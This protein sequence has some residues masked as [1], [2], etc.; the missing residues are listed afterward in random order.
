[1]GEVKNERYD[2]RC[3]F[4]ALGKVGRVVHLYTDGDVKVQA[5]GGSWIFNP[6]AVTKVSQMQTSDDGNDGSYDA[7]DPSETCI[8]SF[9]SSH[10]ERFSAMLKKVF[11]APITGDVHEELVKASAN[12]TSEAL[13]ETGCFHS[14]GL[15]SR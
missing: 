14:D 7:V 12:G 5:V 3:A 2:A 10:Q 13:L 15:S 8:V 9:S 6:L 11:D 4:Q 1:M